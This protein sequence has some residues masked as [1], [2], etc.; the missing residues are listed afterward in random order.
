VRTL[1]QY[2]G[3]KIYH[4]YDSRRSSPGFPDLVLVRPP[5]LLF[6][7]LKVGRRKVTNEQELWLLA[8]GACSAE[9]YVWRPD[10]WPTIE[11]VLSRAGNPA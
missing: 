6:V 10:D 7:E 1:A 8:L 9:T 4:T 11:E 5:R 2:T 3:W